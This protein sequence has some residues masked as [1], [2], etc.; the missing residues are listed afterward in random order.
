M[1]H[2]ILPSLLLG[3]LLC[4]A[5]AHT[6]S[7]KDGP[8]PPLPVASH[9]AVQPLATVSYSG[10]TIGGARWVRPDQD[11]LSPGSGAD[12]AYQAQPITPSVS[13]N[14]SIA[15]IQDGWDG[16]LF[17]YQGIFDPAN[18]TTGCLAGNDDDTA[19]GNSLIASVAL[20]AG[21][22]YTVVTTGYSSG[23]VGSYT[24]AI[25]GP[26]SIALG[27]TDLV[28][29]TKTSPSGVALGTTFTYVLQAQATSATTAAAGVVVSDVLPAS[30]VYVGNSCGASV[31]AG[32]LTWNLGTLAAGSSASCTVTVRNTASICAR[33][34]NTATI[35]TTTPEFDLVN[36]TSTVNNAGANLVN[37]PGFETGTPNAFWT[38]A[39]SDGVDV[40]CDAENCGGGGVG[41]YPHSGNFWAQFDSSDDP[42]TSSLQQSVV[43]PNTA[44]AITFWTNFARCADDQDFLRL[45]IDGTEVWRADG[46]SPL[47]SSG[48]PRGNGGGNAG[49][50]LQ[51]IPLAAFANG[52]SHVIRFES[53]IAAGDDGKGG[54]GSIFLVDD[55]DLEGPPIC[56]A[57]P[58]QPYIYTPVPTNNPLGLL[59]LVS[60]LA[61]LAWFRA[62][63]IA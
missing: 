39:S 29:I 58:S 60:A 46:A 13:G 18:P 34:S 40:I 22:V 48:G 19:V 24:N 11:C 2:S 38:Q 9:S 42:R 56:A 54:G 47:C 32:T 51:S 8:T 53:T 7:A 12:M 30:V 5:T 16:Y 26:G 10:S 61:G 49:Y 14:Y 15:S 27:A 21:S 31:S 43:I 50:V 62:R 41:A 44:S 6:A 36:N 45:T 63:R 33:I 20:M 4:F 59:L 57:L 17:I 3:G 35:T 28:S 55:V 1:T 52:S 23:S 37:D 25:D